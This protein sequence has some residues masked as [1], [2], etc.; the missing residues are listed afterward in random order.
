MFFG[1]KN[2]IKSLLIVIL[3]S[4]LPIN[5]AKA[6]IFDRIMGNPF[7]GKW[8]VTRVKTIMGEEYF[9]LDEINKNC[10]FFKNNGLLITVLD[11]EISNTKYEVLDNKTALIIQKNT[12][13]RMPLKYN[14]NTKELSL[15]TNIFGF[16]GEFY[17]YG[18]T[19]LYFKKR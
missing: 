12:G 13:D 18:D 5:N 10:Y 2:L 6:N 7:S 3:T 8:C 14:R 1:N 11:G 16:L 17:D 15:T 9:S 4:S 19:T